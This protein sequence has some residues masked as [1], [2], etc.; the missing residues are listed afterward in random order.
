MSFIWRISR[1]LPHDE[2]LYLGGNETGTHKLISE[3]YLGK[4]TIDTVRPERALSK[5]V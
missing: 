3:S 5:V 1:S 4:A 2:F